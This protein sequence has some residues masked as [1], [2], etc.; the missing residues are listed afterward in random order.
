MNYQEFLKQRDREQMQDLLKI[1][2]EES[3]KSSLVD[4]DYKKTHYQWEPQQFL[5]QTLRAK[6]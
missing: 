2:K 4:Q 6:S 3:A 1:I 5:P